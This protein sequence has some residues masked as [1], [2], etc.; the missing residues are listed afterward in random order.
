[1][2]R[3]QKCDLTIR[4]KVYVVGNLQTALLGI[5][6]IVSLNLVRRLDAIKRARARAS[7]ARAPL[8]N[9]TSRTNCFRIKPSR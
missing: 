7:R 6:D 5:P 2:R 4:E 9:Q 8:L 1:M 3:L